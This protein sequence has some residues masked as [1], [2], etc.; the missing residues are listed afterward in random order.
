MTTLQNIVEHLETRFRPDLAEPWDNT[1]LLLGRRSTTVSSGITALTLSEDVVDEAVAAGVQVVV[2]HHPILF[3][4]A[5]SLTDTN[6]EGR[7]VLKLI[8]AGIGVYSPHTRFDS[9]AAGINAFLAN[10]LG[11][12]MIATIR[13]LDETPEIGAG[14]IGTLASPMS[15]ESFAKRVSNVCGVDGL[16]VVNGGRPVSKVAIACGA[17]GEFLTDA[18]AFGCDAFVVGE[19]RFHS[20]LEARDAGVSLFV[21]GHYASERPAVEWLAAELNRE[22]AD[23]EWFSSKV[24]RDPLA[25]VEASES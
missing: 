2:T 7:I 14:R 25:W 10:Q 1:G 15:V 8:E 6:A 21:P 16:H 20:A 13:P 9:A 11:L 23:V 5:K 19:C 18:I 12:E 24:E 4:G 3:R 22:F 17:A